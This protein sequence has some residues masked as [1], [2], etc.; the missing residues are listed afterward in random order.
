MTEPFDRI[1]ETALEEVVGGVA[2]PDVSARVAAEHER[3]LAEA[4]AIAAAEAEPL[5]RFVYDRW[6]AWC[7]I[8]ATLLI[9][10]MSAQRYFSPQR[11][12]W[13]DDEVIAAIDRRIQDAWDEKGVQPAERASD[14]EWCRRVHLRLAGRIPTVAELLAFVED[15]RPDK[16]VQCIDRLLAAK[17]E[18][19]EKSTDLAAVNRAWKHFFGFALAPEDEASAVPAAHREL[20][21]ELAEQFAAHGRRPDDLPRWIASSLPFG[22]SSRG[23]EPTETEH[24]LFAVYYT[25]QLP[26]EEV[27]DSL[28]VVA[29]AEPERLLEA[30]HVRGRAA[31]L[32]ELAP[33]VE[34]ATSCDAPAPPRLEGVTQLLAL[35]SSPLMDRATRADGDTLFGRIVRRSAPPEEKVEQLFLAAV[36]RK[37]RPQELDQSLA[38]VRES[39]DDRGL[40]DLWWALLNSNEFQLDH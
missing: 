25:R 22:L 4:R 15:S 31:W 13:P 21:R 23:N 6:M 10:A 26:P 27:F 36:A 9:V 38:I 8:A 35:M 2:P 14:T 16:R 39:D 40:Q 24:P 37:P 12:A 33:S 1:V 17:D 29:D 34:S 32:Q 3:R 30:E 7:A 11:P 28:G 19:A 5:A 20:A 18:P